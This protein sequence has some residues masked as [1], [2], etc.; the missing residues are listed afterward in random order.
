MGSQEF[1]HVTPFD[2]YQAILSEG[3]IPSE[4]HECD[5]GQGVHLARTLSS[6]R[7]WIARLREERDELYYAEFAILAVSVPES[8]TVVSDQHLAYGLSG[9][10]VCTDEPLS[11]DLIGLHGTV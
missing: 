4:A 6:A 2:N 5:C 3:L 1:Y 8:L 11:P 7:D 10:I 9:V